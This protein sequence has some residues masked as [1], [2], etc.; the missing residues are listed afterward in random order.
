M[1]D[2]IIQ[3]FFQVY[4]R[5]R[6]SQC[7]FVFS[8]NNKIN[9]MICVVTCICIGQSSTIWALWRGVETDLSVW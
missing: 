8:K 9:N 4:F 3:A 6:M 7:L 2:E 5:Y 1:D